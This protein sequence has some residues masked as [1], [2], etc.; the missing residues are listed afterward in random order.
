MHASGSLAWMIAL[1]AGS[2]CGRASPAGA[3]S[4]AEDDGIPV[5]VDAEPTPY[6]YV[7]AESAFADLTISTLSAGWDH[8]CGIDIDGEIVCRG[9]DEFGETE[10]PAGPWADVF[11]GHR[12][13]CGRRTDGDIECW[14]FAGGQEAWTRPGGS[15]W[16]GDIELVRI[17][18]GRWGMCGIDASGGA[19]CWG[20]DGYSPEVAPTGQFLS[21][22]TGAGMAC[23]KLSGG[24]DVECWG[25]GNDEGQLD[26]PE[27]DWIDVSVSLW[28][29]CGIRSDGSL[30][31]WGSDARAF[32][33]G[34]PPDT[35]FVSL[36]T[37]GESLCGLHQDGRISC[38]A[39]GTFEWSVFE[40]AFVDLVVGQGF[41]CGRTAAGQVSCSGRLPE[42]AE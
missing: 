14:G 42:S 19:V 23:G 30:V 31:C 1:L 16:P 38:Y 8:V 26:V 24:P 39:P 20:V 37:K 10:A 7:D 21:V 27:G 18:V 9:D 3:D 17:A 2:G 5:E 28:T 13:T 15:N 41:V 22:S 29:P 6:P 34:M 33:D 32:L 36:E 25:V 35:D 12:G 4:G 40:G 11:A